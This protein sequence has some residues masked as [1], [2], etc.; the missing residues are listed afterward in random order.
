MQMANAEILLVSFILLFLFCA[1]SSQATSSVNLFVV[2]LIVYLV[3]AGRIGR[4]EKREAVE[5]SLRDECKVIKVEKGLIVSLNPQNASK[6][7]G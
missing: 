6:K 4:G 3:N 5:E 1:C 2:R 7:H